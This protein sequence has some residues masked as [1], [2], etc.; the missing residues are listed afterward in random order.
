MS[1]QTK[2]E[3]PLPSGHEIDPGVEAAPEVSEVDPRLHPQRPDFCGAEE[4][5]ELTFLRDQNRALIKLVGEL[6]TENR[7]LRRRLDR[8]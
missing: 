5:Q 8:R 3:A 2:S 6:K 7:R 4:V 1:R